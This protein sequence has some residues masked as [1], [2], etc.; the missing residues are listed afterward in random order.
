MGKNLAIFVSDDFFSQC[1]FSR[2]KE[3]YNLFPFSLT[4]SKIFNSFVVKDGNFY[5]LFEFFKN[6]NIE[7]V[8]FAGKVRQNLIFSDL[9]ITAKKFLA[10]IKNLKPEDIMKRVVELLEMNKLKILPQ[11]DVFKE[12]IAEEKIYTYPLTE[13]EEEDVKSGF[14]ILQDILKHNI[15]QSLVIKKGMVLGVEGIE[16]TD[17]LI[18]RIGRYCNDFIFIKGCDE[19]KDVRFDLP[20]IGIETI[21]N[22]KKSG[23][24]V[25]AVKAGKTIILEK[26]KVIE[27]CM[28]N[29][30]KLIGIK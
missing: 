22:I 1:A 15:G 8:F 10:E 9:H 19:N 23:G 29:K 20:V 5:L 25:I 18:K 3:K 7:F 26:E 27:E 2:L 17:E 4:E 16:G 12:E 24:K 11:T 30:I 21:E 28:T 14:I 13:Q 6:N